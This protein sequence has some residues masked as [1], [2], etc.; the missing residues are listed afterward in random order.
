MTFQRHA[1]A[2]GEIHHIRPTE[3]GLITDAKCVQQSAQRVGGIDWT[4]AGAA[5]VH[6]QLPVGINVP[7]LMCDMDGERG[8]ARARRAFDDDD[9]WNVVRDTESFPRGVEFVVSPGVVGGVRR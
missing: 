8:L 6:E 5:K 1:V 4:G 9:R 3:T 7:E 2:G